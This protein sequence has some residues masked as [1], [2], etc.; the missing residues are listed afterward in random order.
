MPPWSYWRSWSFSYREWQQFKRA[1]VEAAQTRDAVDSIDQLLSSV[2][3]AETGQRGFLL[4]GEDRYL[5][6]YNQALQVIPNQL[7]TVRRLLA[8]RANEPGNLARLNSLVDQKLAELRQTIDLRRSQGLASAM[9]VV[10]SDRGQRAMDEIRALVAQIRRTE[11]TGQAQAF[12]RGGGGRANGAAGSRG[13][14]ARALVSLRIRV[15]ALCE[16]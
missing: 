9:A 8:G 12:H 1:N 14:L 4:T 7:G 16:S 6:P 2:T 10:L 5:E 15:G 11:L 13:R 3:D